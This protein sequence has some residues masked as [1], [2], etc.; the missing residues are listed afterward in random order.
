MIASA[1]YNVFFHPLAAFPGP[2]L[3]SASRLAYVA[4]FTRGTLFLDLL[5]M[6]K[7]YGD[8]VRIAPDELSFAHPDAWSDI[9]R[10]HGEEMGKAEWF[11]RSI[12]TSPLCIINEGHE[13]HSRLRRTMAPGFSEKSI[14]DQEHIIR[15]YVDLLLKRLWERCNDGQPVDISDWFNYTTFDIIGDLTFGEPF[16]CLMG[17]NY[18]EWIK[19]IFNSIRLGTIV[20]A[21]SFRPWLK[22]IVLLLAPKGLQAQHK[23]QQLN[24]EAKMRRRIAATQN[25]VDLMQG[26][27]KNEELV[28]VWDPLSNE[29]WH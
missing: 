6:H 8:I 19:S 12:D 15:S 3:H 11:Y 5:E 26:L 21:L 23:R 13:Q 28:G 18:D 24:T 4:Q 9:H 22:R 29:H 1:V 27:F 16:G 14:R 20:Q 17:S 2:L 7:Q 25:R 10:K